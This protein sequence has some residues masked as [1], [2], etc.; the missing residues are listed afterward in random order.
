M[1]G[2][3]IIGALVV[4]CIYYTIH[5]KNLL[6]AR[7]NTSKGNTEKAL[8]NYQ[9]QYEKKPNKIMALNY[10][11][12]LLRDGQYEKAGEILGSIESMKKVTESDKLQVQML[13]GLVKWKTGHLDEA[14]AVYEGLMKDTIT[15][16]IYANLGFLYIIKGDYQ[17]ALSFNR[18]AYEYNDDN[19]VILDNLG[20]TYYR[21]GQYDEAE[22]YLLKAIHSQRAIAENYYHYALVQIA[23]GD[24]DAALDY[25]KKAAKMNINTLS[26]ITRSDV[27][28]AIAKLE[29]RDGEQE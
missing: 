29:G 20:E 26:G 25:L 2:I 6:M 18:E 8:A 22:E 24:E 17:K 10:G 15:T 11:Y 1:V 4:V 12:L 13:L 21:L 27:V 23:K 19:P 3:I 16:N 9:K 5:S 7:Y 28:K 14:I